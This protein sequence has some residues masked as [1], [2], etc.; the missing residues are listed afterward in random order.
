[1]G[2]DPDEQEKL[3]EWY[4]VVQAAKWLGVAPWDL[5]DQPVWWTHWGIAGKVAE[6][7][8]EKTLTERARAKAKKR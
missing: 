4:V 2:E 5:L 1:M 7:R 8:A 3:P 6:A